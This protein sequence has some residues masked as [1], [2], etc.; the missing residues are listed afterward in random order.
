MG[1]PRLVHGAW[2]LVSLVT[3]AAGYLAVP[4]STVR[5]ATAPADAKIPSSAPIV[6]RESSGR[7]VGI[8]EPPASHSGAA[9]PS[10]A[11][12]QL[13][14]NASRALA[15]P[16]RLKRMSTLCKLLDSVSRDNWRGMLDAF[17]QQTISEGR[18]H[19]EE[20]NLVLERIGEVAGEVAVEDALESGKPSELARAKSILIGWSANE[21]EMALAWFRTHKFERPVH[22]E[23]E[24]LMGAL[25]TGLARSA[26][27]LSLD[28]LVERDLVQ[29]VGTVVDGA[30]QHGGFQEGETLLAKVSA[31]T[32]VRDFMKQKL[33]ESLT[34]RRHAVSEVSG[35]SLGLITWL[36][37]YLEQPWAA[38]P[39]YRSMWKAA[40]ADA[41]AVI[42]WLDPRL[43]RMAPQSAAW[44]ARAIA[45][46][47]YKQAPE[48]F[49]AR[50]NSSSNFPAQMDMAYAAASALLANGRAEEVR[51]W[52]ATF[53]NADS[54]KGVERA[55]SNHT[56]IERGRQNAK[57]AQ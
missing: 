40:A 28:L 10:L 1:S 36:E 37:P 25:L 45:P 33:L 15:E 32:D 48:Q 18:L 13:Q 3:F 44:A 21:P 31:R 52:A 4:P 30:I 50:L 53:Q 46:A 49:L 43:S 11:K 38:D 14:E 24:P 47:W 26:P 54:L 7:A 20:W 9:E 12:G 8:Q 22:E 42:G 56:A 55:I 29:F 19:G 41:P 6:P 16:N 57:V 35:E 27:H 39:I 34:D 23:Q 5:H 51:Q 17:A 2:A